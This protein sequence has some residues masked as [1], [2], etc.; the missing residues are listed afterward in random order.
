MQEKRKRRGSRGEG[1]RQAQELGGDSP[2]LRMFKT[3]L[4]RCR[5]SKSRGVGKRVLRWGSS[6][7]EPQITWDRG[8]REDA[9]VCQ[10]GRDPPPLLSLRREVRSGRPPPGEPGTSS[11]LSLSSVSRPHWAFLL[12]LLPLCFHYSRFWGSRRG[13]DFEW[14]SSAYFLLFY[15]WKYSIVCMYHIF[16]WSFID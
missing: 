11:S 7:Y 3:T 8:C 6:M 5:F 13:L 2:R 10:R 14:V 9:R 16:M 1:S 4:E 12:L 15:S